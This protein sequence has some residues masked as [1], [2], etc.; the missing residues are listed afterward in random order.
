MITIQAD[1]TIVDIIDKI[2]TESSDEIILDFP[3]W[4]PILHNYI[5]LKILKS[6]VGDKKLIIATNDRIGRR[7]GKR[8]WIEYSLI[9]DSAF[10][11]DSTQNVLM[12]HNFTFFEYLRFQIYSYL[13]EIKS[14]LETN[15]KLNSL[16]KYSKLY[17]EQTGIHVFIWALFSSILLLAFVYYFAVSKTYISI[18]PEV[19]IKKEAL[20]F[21]F[22]EKSWNDVLWNNKYVKI[23]S[24]YQKATLSEVFP[25]SAVQ[26]NVSQISHGKVRLYNTLSEEITLKVHTRLQSKD[27]LIFELTDWA[28]I[29][30]AIHDNFWKVSPWVTEV[31]VQAQSKDIS[32]QLIGARG[33][34]VTETSLILPWL[35]AD[36]QKEIYAQSMEDFS[37]GS[38]TVQKMVVQSDID[39]AQA[40]FKEKLKNEVL[41]NIKDTISQENELNSSRIDI[42]T[43]DKSIRYGEPE[44]HIQEGIKDGS[45]VENFTLTGS[46]S[47]QVYTYNKDVLIQKLKTIVHEKNLEG[48]EKVAQI[49]ESSLRMSEILY[50]QESPFEMKATFEVESLYLHDFLHKQN[51]YIEQLKSKI[52]GLPQDEAAKILLND[53]K[54]SNVDIRIRPFFVN[55]ISS[56]ANNIIFKVE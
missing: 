51:T 1:D 48:I 21:I 33:N 49:D 20:N 12:K 40:L 52:R 23:E 2:E 32:G 30:P 47:L 45:L 13:R 44:I 50:T 11:K 16:W 53:P 26:N 19:S 29:P 31:R 5:S 6:K 7:I 14:A 9:K 15:K 36:L 25:S 37:G 46:I 18:T 27:G 38:D 22:K 10:I 55:S 39:S 3:L 54:V 56:I 8:L 42:L 34:I 43:G 24:V 17:Q 4:H 35:E 28:T 41:N